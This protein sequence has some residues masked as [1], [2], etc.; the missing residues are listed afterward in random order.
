MLEVEARHREAEV[1]QY[2]MLGLELLLDQFDDRRGCGVIA[3]S[4]EAQAVR[5][6]GGAVH[7]DV[8]RTLDRGAGI[9]VPGR[10]DFRVLVHAELVVD[11]LI[12]QFV[13]VVGDDGVQVPVVEEVRKQLVGQQ[14]GVVVAIPFA[15]LLADLPFLL[16]RPTDRGQP[17]LEALAVEPIYVF[18][19]VE[20]DLPLLGV[21]VDLFLEHFG[22][23]LG[24]GEHWNARS[25][26]DDRHDADALLVARWEFRVAEPARM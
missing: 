21:F 15:D 13:E 20:F 4:R 7:L 12:E 14:A 2:E 10:D 24:G 23:I 8:E 11:R 6:R 22:Q 9:A 26:S 18:E 17:G 3:L 19:P 1:D 25:R 5:L 16:L